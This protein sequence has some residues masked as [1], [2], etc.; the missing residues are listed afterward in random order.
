MPDNEACNVYHIRGKVQ[1]VGYRAWTKRMA[2]RLRVRG[3][4]RNETDGT[5]TTCVAGPK[6]QVAAL[7]AHCRKG[8]PGSTVDAVVEE[9]ASTSD[10]GG[11]SGF[12]IRY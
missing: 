8:P 4:V 10:I 5:V 9:P 1:N 11:C 3:W 12:I 6:E 7:V 2:D